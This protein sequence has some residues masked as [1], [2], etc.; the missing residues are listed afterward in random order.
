MGLKIPV[1]ELP[2]F[3][4]RWEWH[5]T[6]PPRSMGESPY[7]LFVGRLEKLK[8]PQTLIPVFHRYRKAQLWI[9][10]AGDYEQHLKDLAGG[11]A[12]IRF[13]GHMPE[14]RLQALY[15][16]AV[17]LIVPSICFEVFSL[18]II[19]AFRQRTPAIVRN[20]GGILEII[21]GSGGGFIYNTD[22]ELVTAMD[23]L[24]ADSSYRDRLG[25]RGYDTYQQEWTAEAHLQRY[26]A[27]IREIAETRGKYRLEAAAGS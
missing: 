3:T 11:D 12:N 17:A 10:G 23:Q 2:Y 1:V 7:F 26:I 5:A 16:R 4:S 25:A 13:L 24:L 9:A 8:G 15:R 22:G 18:V 21:E 19:E 20:I 14:K 27:L 6:T